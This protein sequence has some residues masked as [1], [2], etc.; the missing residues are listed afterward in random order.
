[1]LK[2]EEKKGIEKPKKRHGLRNFFITLL[3]II[4]VILIGVGAT[5]VYNIPVVSAVFGFNKPKDLGVKYTAAD[6]SALEQKIPLTITAERVDYGGDPNQIFSGSAPVDTQNTS[7]EITAFLNRFA[8]ADSPLQN[9]QV[10][11]IEGGVEVSGQ[12]NMYVRSPAY[13][14]IMIT[15][16]GTKSVS[17]NVT[18]AKLG[19]FN[20]P[21]KYLQ[22]INDWA[23]KKVNERMAEIPGFSITQLDYHDGYDVFKGTVPAEVKSATGGWTDLLLK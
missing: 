13:A 16:T 15:R 14:K 19:V 8:L 1:M 11:M 10:K 6:L 20:V 7:A 18:S 5:G 23:N 21:E 9:T 22:Q 3:I 2:P 17:I 4:I 12:L